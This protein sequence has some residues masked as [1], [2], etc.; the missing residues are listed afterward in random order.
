MSARA[1]RG[2]QGDLLAMEFMT[3]DEGNMVKQVRLL[4]QRVAGK[5]QALRHMHLQPATT[6][7]GR[8]LALQFTP[9]ID[10]REQPITLEADAACPTMLQLPPGPAPCTV[11]PLP[12][13]PPR[14]CPTPRSAVFADEAGCQRVPAPAQAAAA[15]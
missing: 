15:V 10:R 14:P 9:S 2:S 12:P 13:P 4:Q 11:C 7:A 3:A 8:L 6:L 1:R 5:R